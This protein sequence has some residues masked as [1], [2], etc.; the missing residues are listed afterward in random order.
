MKRHAN[1]VHRS[2]VLALSLAALIAPA[3]WSQETAS[4]QSSATLVVPLQITETLPLSF[5]SLIKTAAHT[6][7]LVEVEFHPAIGPVGPL[8]IADPTKVIDPDPGDHTELLLRFTGDPTKQVVINH[9]GNVVVVLTTGGGS[10]QEQMH[11]FPERIVTDSS[12]VIPPSATD[13][14]PMPAG[15][16]VVVEMGGILHVKNDNVPGVYSANVDVTVS[17]L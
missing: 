13:T 5:G 11:F 4:I 7:A 2:L 10:A 16:E 15:G 12:A 17:Y 9:G 6:G 8:T 3:A 14:Y 1:T